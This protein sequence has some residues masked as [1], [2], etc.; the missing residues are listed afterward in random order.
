M[1]HRGKSGQEIRQNSDSNAELGTSNVPDNT[2]DSKVPSRQLDVSRL[3]NHHQVVKLTSPRNTSTSCLPSHSARTR[4]RH[5]RAWLSPSL[6]DYSMADQYVSANTSSFQILTSADL[7]CLRR[8]PLL[9]RQSRSRG[10]HGRNGLH[11]PN[12]R[13]SIPLV[14]PL[15]AERTRF[16]SVLGSGSRLAYSLRL[17][18]GCRV[19]CIPCRHRRSGPDRSEQRELRSARLAWNSVDLGAARYSGFLQ[20]FRPQDPEHD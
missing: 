12:R 15:C 10:Q 18:G 4:K 1:Q 3:G 17:D 8:P 9:A 2:E 5:G 14:R 6:P 7:P 13:R 11:Q 16:S 19:A 20:Y